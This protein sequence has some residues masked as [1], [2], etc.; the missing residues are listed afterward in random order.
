M[1]ETHDEN[2][3]SVL[4]R[5]DVI[6]INV[7]TNIGQPTMASNNLEKFGKKTYLGPWMTGE[8]TLLERF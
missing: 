7:S 5:A 8:K 2:S 6:N 1:E 3:Y 4:S